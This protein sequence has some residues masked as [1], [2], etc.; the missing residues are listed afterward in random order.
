MAEEYETKKV[1]VAGQIICELIRQKIL[2]GEL[3]RGGTMPVDQAAGAIGRLYQGIWQAI[4]KAP[5]AKAE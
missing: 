3:S 2:P 5:K 4:D 1:E